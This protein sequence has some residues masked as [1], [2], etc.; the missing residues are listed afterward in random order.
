MPPELVCC[1]ISIIFALHT[2]YIYSLRTCQLLQQVNFPI[3]PF[4]IL[5]NF[6]KFICLL[7]VV[8]NNGERVQ[9]GYLQGWLYRNQ[10]KQSSALQS[11]VGFPTH[12]SGTLGAQVSCFFFSKGRSS[13]WFYEILWSRRYLFPRVSN[14]QLREGDRSD[15]RCYTRS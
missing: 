7:G 12:I 13:F 6:C 2:F 3:E 15:D 14:Y 9:C 5:L 8:W 10:H 1:L 11:C 4:W